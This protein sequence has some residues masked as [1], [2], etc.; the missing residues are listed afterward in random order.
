MLANLKKNKLTKKI[1]IYGLFR[2]KE[3]FIRE[4]GVSPKLS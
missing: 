2:G 4:K 1:E 3:A